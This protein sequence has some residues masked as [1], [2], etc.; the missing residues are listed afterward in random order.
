[1]TRRP[2][3][4]PGASGCRPAPPAGLRCRDTESYQGRATDQGACLTSGSSGRAR[5]AHHAWPEDC[6]KA[7]AAE[8]LSVRPTS[9]ASVHRQ[10]LCPKGPGRF[11]TTPPT[12]P[13]PTPSPSGA[14]SVVWRLAALARRIP[15]AMLPRHA[16]LTRSFSG[17]HTRAGSGGGA[18]ELQG[19]SQTRA[20][21]TLRWSRAHSRRFGVTWGD[22]LL[23]GAFRVPAPQPVVRG[24]G[25]WKMEPRAGIQDRRRELP[26]GQSSRCALSWCPCLGS[27]A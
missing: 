15:G 26:G 4:F 13:P 10:E 25:Q 19:G 23:S 1:M 8:R 5:L 21:F 9:E 6:R 3:R 17:P 16:G 7:A 18:A 24:C 11:S 2:T 27:R 12:A 20:P 14:V 22:S